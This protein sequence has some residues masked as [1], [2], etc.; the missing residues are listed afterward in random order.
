MHTDHWIVKTLTDTKDRLVTEKVLKEELA[1]TA[2][3]SMKVRPRRRPRRRRQPPP[4]D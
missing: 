1:R 4:T 2:L 3:S